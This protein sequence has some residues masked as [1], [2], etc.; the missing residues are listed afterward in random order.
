[1]QC[2]I[3]KHVKFVFHMRN[4]EL[5]VFVVTLHQNDLIYY[6]LFTIYFLFLS[7]YEKQTCNL[8]LWHALLTHLDVGGVG[9]HL[10]QHFG[11]IQKVVAIGAGA[12]SGASITGFRQVLG[13]LAVAATIAVT[14]AA[15]AAAI[16]R[17]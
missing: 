1:M 9:K 6:K 13:A 14:A 10:L 5:I 17:G 12:I 8:I 4:H 2:F 7:L 16:V 15:A 11:L 3:W